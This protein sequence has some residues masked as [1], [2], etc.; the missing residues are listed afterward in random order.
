MIPSAANATQ[1]RQLTARFLRGPSAARFAL[2][3]CA[4]GNE[5]A[6]GIDQYLQIEFIHWQGQVEHSSTGAPD[7]PLEQVEME[8]LAEPRVA[9]C[10]VG[11]A[12]DRPRAHMNI[13]HRSD[14]GKLHWQG[15]LLRKRVEPCAQLLAALIETPNSA[16]REHMSEYGD[17]GRHAQDIVIERSGM[18]EGLRPTRV[19]AIHDVGAP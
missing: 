9:P 15:A 8:Q 16:S 4:F 19:E 3:R 18:D 7:S 14:A 5:F 11:I 10:R 6:H 17:P 13:H 2:K 1:L 12:H